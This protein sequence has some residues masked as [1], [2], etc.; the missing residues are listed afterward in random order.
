M[1]NV[2]LFCR[3]HHMKFHEGG[4]TVQLTDDGVIAQPP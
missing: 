2:A 4:W 3:R 1:W